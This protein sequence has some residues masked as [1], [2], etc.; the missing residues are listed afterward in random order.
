MSKKKWKPRKKPRISR[1]CDDC[2]AR[3]THRMVGPLPSGDPVRRY[4]C[5]ECRDLWVR[6]QKNLDQVAGKYPKEHLAVVEGAR[7][8]KLK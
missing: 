1:K 7:F 2:G 6:I 3:A 5:K 8:E 4:L